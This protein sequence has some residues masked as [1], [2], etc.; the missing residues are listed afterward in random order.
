MGDKL[1]E[2]LEQGVYGKP[3]IKPEEKKLFLSTFAER[4]H[5]A[6]T[7]RQVR[8]RGMY[9]KAIDVMKKEKDVHL[10]LNGDLGYSAYS[11]Y[12]NEANKHRVAFTIINDSYDTPIGLVLASSKALPESRPSFFIK[13]EQYQRDMED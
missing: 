9:D 1:K 12:V 6:L 3:E 4:V 11:N 7:N 10:Y 8:H 13:D 2:V 5:L